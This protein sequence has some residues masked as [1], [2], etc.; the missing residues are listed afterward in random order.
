MGDAAPATVNDVEYEEDW[1]PDDFQPLTF[2]QLAWKKIKGAPLV[3]VG[4]YSSDGLNLHLR[5]S[6]QVLLLLLYL[7]SWLHTK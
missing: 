1:L 3:G 4:E 2:R 7:S 5:M 6:L